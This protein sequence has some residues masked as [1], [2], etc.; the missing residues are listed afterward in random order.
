MQVCYHYCMKTLLVTGGCGFIGSNFVRYMLKKHNNIRIIN[1]DAL[2]YAG[3]RENLA[4]SEKNPRYT[5][6]Q[7]D[8]ARKSRLA[9]LFKKH[10]V[11]WIVHFAAETHVDRSIMHP[12]RF[13]RTNIIGSHNLLALAVQYHIARYIHI[14]TD[15]VYGALTQ[16][17]QKPFTEQ[18]PLLPNNP[19]SASKAS[20][21]LLTRSYYKTYGLPIIIT[22]CANN[23]GPYQFPEKLISLAITN[24]LENQPIPIYGD[25]LYI[26][27]W[28]YVRDHCTAIDMILHQ[29]IPGEIYNIGGTSDIPNSGIITRILDI[30]K[31]PHSLI[32]YVKDRPGHDRRYSLDS[33]KLRKE[34]GWT[35][36]SDLIQGLQETVRWYQK[37]QRW[38]SALKSKKYKIYYK[39]QYNI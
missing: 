17:R 4:D 7:C 33:T 18:S 28:L 36:G 15:E 35:P 13:I 20:A 1:V 9:A 38:W 39:R 5:F 29:G 25:G 12:E 34:L 37:N 22:R 30:L 31:K 14:S 32:T 24:A 2:T 19:Y 10:A 6:Y 23:Y 21:D 27:D 11:D 16:P 3:S 8:I 26:R